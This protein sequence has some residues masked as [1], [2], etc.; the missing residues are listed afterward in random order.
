MTRFRGTADF[1]SENVILLCSLLLAPAGIAANNTAASRSN[2]A[3]IYFPGPPNLFFELASDMAGCCL[4]SS[5]SLAKG[6]T[7][8]F[9]Y[10]HYNEDLKLNLTLNRFSAWLN[11]G[12]CRFASS[13][14]LTNERIRNSPENKEYRDD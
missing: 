2:M 8:K 10:D 13:H 5:N 7:L 1:F 11:A 9:I 12:P 3:R 6:S 14:S 4:R